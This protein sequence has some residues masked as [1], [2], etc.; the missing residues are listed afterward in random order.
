M[1][2]NKTFTA[3]N[4]RHHCRKCGILVCG[5]CSK[6][7]TFVPEVSRMHSVRICDD[8]KRRN[9]GISSSSSNGGVPCGMKK[10]DQDS[11]IMQYLSHSRSSRNIKSVKRFDRLSASSTVDFFTDSDD[12]DT[13]ETKQKKTSTL[14]EHLSSVRDRFASFASSS[15]KDKEE[16]AA[17]TTPIPKSPVVKKEDVIKE[18][19]L[20]K[21]GTRFMG[22]SKRHVMLT[23]KV[24]CYSSSKPKKKPPV[25]I[26]LHDIVSVTVESMNPDRF[27]L[28]LRVASRSSSHLHGASALSFR[29]ESKYVVKKWCEKLN[30]LAERAKKDLRERTMIGNRIPNRYCKKKKMLT[31][32]QIRVAD[33]VRCVLGDEK[34]KLPVQTFEY[35]ENGDR[36]LDAKSSNESD[37]QTL[38]T[39]PPD[40]ET[41]SSIK[42]LS[43]RRLSQ[44]VRRASASSA[45]RRQSQTRNLSKSEQEL[46]NN[47]SPPSSALRRHSQTYNHSKSDQELMN[48]SPPPSPIARDASVSRESLESH[49][50]Q[51]FHTPDA[52]AFSATVDA[53]VG[54]GDD[55]FMVDVSPPPTPTG[56]DDDGI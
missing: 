45:L 15:P 36:V 3:L 21:A 19:E 50:F 54:D 16:E 44:R 18:G 30:E 12:E 49:D 55:D 52:V 51:D 40:S 38:L 48:I 25:S 2:C 46:M 14:L 34:T 27:N 26:P 9:K 47:I 22:F 24:F 13:A 29:G 32:S 31:V 10:M 35:D 39:T 20:E 4:R 6:G 28:Y 33:F 56:S 7:K 5:S 1:C 53:L 37:I 42:R 41:S 43:Q 23:K 17:T 11:A 8:C